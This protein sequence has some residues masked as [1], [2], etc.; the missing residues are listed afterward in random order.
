MVERNNNEEQ[1]LRI[2]R[3]LQR[4]VKATAELEALNQPKVTVELTPHAPR[5]RRVPPCQ[6]D[7][8]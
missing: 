5:D 7:H 1:R 2:A 6:R 3:T 8:A 4:L